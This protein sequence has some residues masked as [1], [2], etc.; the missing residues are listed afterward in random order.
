MFLLKSQQPTVEAPGSPL[1]E[2]HLFY[3]S[4]IADDGLCLDSALELDLRGRFIIAQGRPGR[5][6]GRAVRGVRKG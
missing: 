1:P 4:W 6:A 3:H 5:A 2:I